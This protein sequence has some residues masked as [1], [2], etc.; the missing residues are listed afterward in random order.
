MQWLHTEELQDATHAWDGA[1]VE[2]STNAGLSF[3]QIAPVG[4][5]P[6]SIYGHPASPFVDETPCLAGDGGWERIE[7]DLSPYAASFIQLQLTFGS[8]GLVVEEGWYVDDLEVSPYGGGADWLAATPS[9]GVVSELSTDG[10]LVVANTQGFDYGELRQALI[11]LTSNDPVTPAQRAHIGLSNSSRKIEVIVI[12]PGRVTPPG[13]V[14][15]DVGDDIDFVIEADAYHH[16]ANILTGENVFEQAL[17]LAQ[18]NFQWATV[19]VASTGQLYVA[20]APNLVTNGLTELWLVDQGFTN[21]TFAMEA[22]RDHDGDGAPAWHEFIAGTDPNLR[23]DVLALKVQDA[24]AGS[25]ASPS[26]SVQHLRLTWPSAEQ[27]SY[28]LY[29]APNMT[30]AFSVLVGNIPATPPQ[31]VHT[32]SASFYTHRFF[33]IE[34]R[35][36]PVE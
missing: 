34:A 28:S 22:T 5:Y 7:F 12:G 4:G 19:S 8:D 2:I 32:S 9:N 1:I 33:R 35:F 10:I 23:Q 13:P 14:V 18:T 25:N 36:D 11:L 24:N 17:N 31:N 16:I 15:V 6:Y 3:T 21:D 29:S 20:F 27:R 26:T 30:S